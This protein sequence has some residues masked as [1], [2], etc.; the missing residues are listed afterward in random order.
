MSACATGVGAVQA[1]DVCIILGTAHIISICLDEPIF[2]PEVGLQ[3][4]HVDGKFLKLVPP[5]IA[6]PNLDWYLETM[7]HADRAHAEA[8]Q[9]D[10]FQYLEG[11]LAEIPPGAEGVVYHPY[12]SP[13]GE[14]CPF[15]K[16]TAKGNFLGW[17]CSTPVIIC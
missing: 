5:A 9:L 6:T 10:V 12:L 17:A 3:M 1:G 16:L 7:G 4:T 2:E 13:M 8:V 14:R 15:T 11:Q